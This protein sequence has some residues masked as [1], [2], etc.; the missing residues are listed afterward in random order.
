MLLA[1][2]INRPVTLLTAYLAVEDALNLA[3]LPVLKKICV[4]VL[5]D[6]TTG[7]KFREEL[8]SC[9]RDNLSEYKRDAIRERNAILQ[10]GWV[11]SVGIVRRAL[12]K[13]KF[14]LSYHPCSYVAWCVNLY[15]LFPRIKALHNRGL[16]V[17]GPELAW[18]ALIGVTTL[19][20]DPRKGDTFGVTIDGDG[21]EECD[22]FHEDVDWF[23]LFICKEQKKNGKVSWLQNGRRQEIWRLQEQAPD[24]GETYCE[25]RYQNTLKFLEEVCSAETLCKEDM[26]LRI[27]GSKASIADYLIMLR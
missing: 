20:I 16:I 3:S 5:E 4:K 6:E 21:E 15:P 18:E 24:E 12:L 1:Y 17:Q 22:Y 11:T 23:M 8:L 19:S 9:T 26:H 27:R 7:A 10:A 14:P 13:D 2:H 25:Y